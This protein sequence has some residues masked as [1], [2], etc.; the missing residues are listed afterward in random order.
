MLVSYGT[1]PSVR[2]TE[3][4]TISGAVAPAVQ[5]PI[6]IALVTSFPPS[7][8]DLNEYGYH[9]A[10]AM[11]DDPGV[12]LTVLADEMPGQDSELSGFHVE[13]CWRF[14]SIANPERLMRAIEKSKAD[15]VWFNIG[16]STFARSP[17]PAFMALTVPALT[18]L[19]GCYTHITLHT[20]FERISL[21]D[22]GIRF[23]GLYRVAG[24]IATRLLLLSGDVSVLLPSFRNEILNNYRVSPDRVHARPHGTFEAQSASSPQQSQNSADRNVIL[25]FGYWGTYKK[26]D[27]LLDSIDKVRESVPDAVLVI[28]GTNHPSAPG[29]LESLQQ[30]WANHPGVRFLGYVPETDLPSLFRAASVLALPYSSAAGT[31]GVLHQACQYG[32]PVVAAAIPEITEIAQEENVAIEF[33]EQGDG[34]ALTGHL[35]RLLQSE[36][37]RCSLSRQNLSAAQGTPIS[38]V[39]GDYLRLFQQRVPRLKMQVKTL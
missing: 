16:F 30:K 34:G 9:L 27:L 26:V 3:P 22:A 8:G 19:M 18:R 7:V 37:L 13:R 23:P 36:D 32:L 20:V 2:L 10:C 17:I 5:R 33:Y 4:S 25:A 14:D 35:I 1:N 11:R 31:S 38:Q 29:Y 6:R 15:V 39:V 24:R 12:E 21:K 28:A